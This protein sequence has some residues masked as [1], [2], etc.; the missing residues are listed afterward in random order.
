MN[1]GFRILSVYISVLTFSEEY[2]HPA[3]TKKFYIYVSNV[4]VIWM[5]MVTRK[6]FATIGI[7]YLY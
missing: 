7:L 1:G 3:L 4:P 5:D 2:F 6:S